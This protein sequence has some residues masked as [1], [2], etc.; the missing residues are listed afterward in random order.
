MR[1]GDKKSPILLKKILITKEH[2][3]QIATKHLIGTTLFITGIRIGAGNSI[4]VFIDGDQGVGINDCVSLSRAIESALDRNAGDFSL[5]VSSHG[6][7]TPLTMPR[8]YPRH[9]G[10]DFE[11]KLNDGSRAE[12][13]LKHCDENGLMLEYSVRENKPLGK[14][15]IAVIK[16]QQI[17]YNQIKESKI[18]L[19]F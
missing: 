3:E 17:A 7:A 6:A 9:L 2:I 1:I 11:I 13:T 16:Q 19:K 15:K 4:S 18:K 12:G 8:Q 10:R 5:Y 14:G